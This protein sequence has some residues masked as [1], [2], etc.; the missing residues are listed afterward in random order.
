MPV[1]K[2]KNSRKEILRGIRDANKRST[3][4]TFPVPHSVLNQLFDQLEEQ[5]A[6]TGC[7]H[8]LRLTRE[9]I[10]RQSLPEIE[11]ISWLE[12][13]GG[14]CDCEV[15]SNVEEIVSVATS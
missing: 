2:E 4:D 12:K 5:L 10:S 14:Y 11:V 8:T 9:F 1:K 13:N 7:D 6:T 3:Q 15:L